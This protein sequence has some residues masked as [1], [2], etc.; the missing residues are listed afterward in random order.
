MTNTKQVEQKVF[1]WTG[2]RVERIVI[3]PDK[4]REVLIP[5]V[6]KVLIRIKQEEMAKQASGGEQR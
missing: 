5:W 4:V 2:K 6:Y 1:P 3:P